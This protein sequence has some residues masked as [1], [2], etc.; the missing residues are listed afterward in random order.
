MQFL[1]PKEF[2][3]VD[4]VRGRGSLPGGID[5]VDIDVRGLGSPVD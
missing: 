3:E 4:S 1:R 2:G 5:R